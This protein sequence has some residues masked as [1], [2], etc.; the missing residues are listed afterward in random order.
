MKQLIFNLFIS[1]H[2][3]FDSIKDKINNPPEKQDFQKVSHKLANFIKLKDEAKAGTYKRKPKDEEDK[4]GECT[5]R[6]LQIVTSLNI[7]HWCRK[8]RKEKISS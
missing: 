1:I 5:K 4:P 8:L 2:F 3:Q 6:N 7:F